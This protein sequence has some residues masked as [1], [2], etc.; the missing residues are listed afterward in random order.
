MLGTDLPGGWELGHQ[1]AVAPYSEDSI[2]AKSPSF[3]RREAHYFTYL[4]IRG[5]RSFFT[6]AG[7]CWGCVMMAVASASLQAQVRAPP[8][9]AAASAIVFCAVAAFCIRFA[10]I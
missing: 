4:L 1:G 9:R 5:S 3:L 8:S 2:K 10:T 6:L 7:M